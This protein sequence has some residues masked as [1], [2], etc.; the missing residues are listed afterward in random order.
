MILIELQGTGD[1]GIV[2]SGG[3][4]D[5]HGVA[6][7]GF[8]IA[9]NLA[10]G[11]RGRGLLPGSRPCGRRRSGNFDG[12]WIHGTGGDTIGDGTPANR[13]VVGGNFNGVVIE[14]AAARPPSAAT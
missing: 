2:V 8:Q 10:A 13:N 3:S 1:D 7:Q 5:L 6:L 12:I 4:V 11:R 14:N 9:V